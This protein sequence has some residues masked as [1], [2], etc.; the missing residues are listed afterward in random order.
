L[1]PDNIFQHAR[2]GRPEGLINPVLYVVHSIFPQSASAQDVVAEARYAK[3]F[4]FFSSEKNAFLS[5][6]PPDQAHG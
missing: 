4:W 1:L 5:L 6:K 2:A 3:V